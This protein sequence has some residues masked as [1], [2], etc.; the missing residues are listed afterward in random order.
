SAAGFVSQVTTPRYPHQTYLCGPVSCNFISSNMEEDCKAACDPR[1][2]PL[3]GSLLRPVWEATCG[4]GV[5]QG[6][7]RSKAIARELQCGDPNNPGTG[8]P[9]FQCQMIGYSSGYACLNPDTPEALCCRQEYACGNVCCKYPQTSCCGTPPTC[10]D[11]ETD[12]NN[13]GE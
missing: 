2:E 9:D 6:I 5:V 10:V 7:C 13:C 11:T 3:P 12:I 4:T 1:A 8:S